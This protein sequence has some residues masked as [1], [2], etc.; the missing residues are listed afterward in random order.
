V[1][2]TSAEKINWKIKIKQRR[3]GKTDEEMK[4]K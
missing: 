2:A 3:E 1:I 4:P